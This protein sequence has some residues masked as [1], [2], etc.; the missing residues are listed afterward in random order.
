M[1]EKEKTR[2]MCDSDLKYWYYISSFSENLE[3]NNFL[4]A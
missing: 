4:E 3:Y 2:S 1:I